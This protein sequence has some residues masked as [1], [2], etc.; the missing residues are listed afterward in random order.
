M[1]DHDS[2]TAWRLDHAWMHDVGATRRYRS[3]DGIVGYV[4]GEIIVDD[5]TGESSIA[6]RDGRGIALRPI[7]ESQR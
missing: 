4:E 3:E 2:L 1:I 5:T 7:P 6:V